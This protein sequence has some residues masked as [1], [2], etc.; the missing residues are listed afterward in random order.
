VYGY[1]VPKDY[2]NMDLLPMNKQAYGGEEYGTVL[3]PGYN[4]YVFGS[5]FAFIPAPGWPVG[6]KFIKKELGWFKWNVYEDF[7]YTAVVKMGVLPGWWLDEVRYASTDKDPNEY[8]RSKF[9]TNSPKKTY[10]HVFNIDTTHYD[11]YGMS[12]VHTFKRTCLPSFKKNQYNKYGDYC[13]ATEDKWGNKNC[14]QGEEHYGR[15]LSVEEEDPVLMTGDDDTP[16]AP[17]RNLFG[18]NAQGL[19]RLNGGGDKKCYKDYKLMIRGRF[20]TLHQNYYGPNV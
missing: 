5:M 9:C 7:D 17:G 1:A 3:H 10:P 12:S 16:M 11:P 6:S 18:S 19:R 8:T 20:C 2:A 15:R 14:P 4:E 13:Q